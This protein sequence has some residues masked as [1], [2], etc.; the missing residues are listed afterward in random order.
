MRNVCQIP[1][2][3]SFGETTNMVHG[4]SALHLCDQPINARFA[5]AGT[6]PDVRRQLRAKRAQRKNEATSGSRAGAS[7]YKHRKVRQREATTLSARE[8]CTLGENQVRIRTPGTVSRTSVFKKH[9][10]YFLEGVIKNLARSKCFAV[11]V[12]TP[13]N[14]LN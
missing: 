7:S 2:I 10:A 11:V 9:Q 13:H 14:H 12:I 4:R 1:R 3:L 8:M 6:A 5:G